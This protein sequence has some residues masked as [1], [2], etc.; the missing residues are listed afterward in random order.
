M[1]EYRFRIGDAFPEQEP[2]ARFVTVL[3]FIH[4]DWRRT[5]QAMVDSTGAPGGEGARLLSFRQLVG[6]SHEATE[7][8]TGSRKR[9]EEVDTFV[10]S[11][12]AEALGQYDRV[13]TTLAPIERWMRKQRDITFHYPKMVRE[14]YQADQEA[15]ATALTA[16]ADETSS[17][18]LADTHA[19]ISLDF[20]D[21]VAVHLLGFK[22]PEEQ[23]ELR[24][25]VQALREAAY[26]LGVF[27][28]AAVSTYLGSC[29]PGAIATVE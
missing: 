7:F 22:L 3:A 2:V 16:A 25:L 29:E 26:A 20:A 14:S 24:R 15:I 21:A 8:L 19:G 6:Y 13:F 17:I 18:T 12:N 1:P 11:L 9:Y 10:S 27:V 23:E 4:N 28:V 5:M